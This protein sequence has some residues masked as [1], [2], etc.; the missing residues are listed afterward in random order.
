VPLLFVDLDNTLIDRAS[1][2]GRWSAA[3]VARRG[4]SMAG[5]TTIGNA[6]R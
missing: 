5:E 4:G 1:A 6:L 2:V 3:F